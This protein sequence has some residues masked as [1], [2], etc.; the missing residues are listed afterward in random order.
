M[1]KQ[2]EQPE[3]ERLRLLAVDEAQAEDR[4][5]QNAPQ[6]AAAGR[7]GPADPTGRSEEP[8]RVSLS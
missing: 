3:D 6:A 2:R 1:A 5:D 7:Y 4:A 8:D